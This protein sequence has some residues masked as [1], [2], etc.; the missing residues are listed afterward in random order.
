MI[1]ENMTVSLF[2]NSSKLSVVDTYNFT[3]ITGEFQIPS[4]YAC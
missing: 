1:E 4:S 2:R 3:A